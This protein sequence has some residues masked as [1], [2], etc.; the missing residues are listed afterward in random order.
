M[1][2]VFFLLARCSRTSNVRTGVANSPAQSPTC[3]LRF[4]SRTRRST[5]LAS[6]VVRS[7]RCQTMLPFGP[8]GPSLRSVQ[9]GG[10]FLPWDLRHPSYAP[11]GP[12]VGWMLPLEPFR[13]G[14]RRAREPGAVGPSLRLGVS[15]RSIL[16]VP[17]RPV[18]FLS[19]PH[20][21]YNRRNLP[22]DRQP[23]QVRSRPVRQ[24]PIVIHTQ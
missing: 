15:P 9:R 2:R 23:G 8:R 12:Q 21:Q 14:D 6:F 4:A 13:Q 22:C 3:P 5:G 24:Q 20:R 18:A 7:L 11:A 16:L 19:F 1:S 10:I 17:P